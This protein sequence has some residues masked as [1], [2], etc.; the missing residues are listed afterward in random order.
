MSFFIKS[1]VPYNIAKSQEGYHIISFKVR[2]PDEV[3]GHQGHLRILLI[4]LRYSGF[5]IG[6]FAVSYLKINSQ[7][8]L[9]K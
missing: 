3:K 4:I 8:F 9:E 5:H 7:L 1:T 6:V 2:A